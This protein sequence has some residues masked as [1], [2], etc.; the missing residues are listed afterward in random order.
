MLCTMQ[1]LIGRQWPFEISV[2][3]GDITFYDELAADCESYL[4]YMT[5]LRPIRASRIWKNARIR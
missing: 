3:N 5:D 1:C 2:S 4:L